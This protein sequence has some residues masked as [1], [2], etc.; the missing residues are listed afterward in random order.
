MI[1][2][3]ARDNEPAL[4]QVGLKIPEHAKLILKK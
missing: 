2:K 3:V 4:R 1:G